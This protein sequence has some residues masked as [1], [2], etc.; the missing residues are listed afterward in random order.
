MSVEINS[1]NSAKP[2][3]LSSATF[4]RVDP[5]LYFERHLR[6]GLR[7][8]SQRGVDEFRSVLQQQGSLT[9]A[10]IGGDSHANL[11]NNCFGSC[12]VRS[13]HTSVACGIVVGTTETRGGAGIYPNVEI[14]RGGFS[15]APSAEE[16]VMSQRVSDLVK[17]MGFGAENFAVRIRQPDAEEEEDDEEDVREAWEKEKG[18]RVE[19][20]RWLVYTAHIQVLSRTGPPFDLVWAALMGA[21]RDVEVPEFE[22]DD[23]KNLFCVARR[24]GRKLAF[25]FS[26]VPYSSTFG[27]TTVDKGRDAELFVQGIAQED[28]DMDGSSGAAQLEVVVLAD[29]DGEIE[30]TCAPSQMDVV[31]DGEGVL[32]GFSFSAVGDHS[33][34]GQDLSHPGLV[35]E[36][37]HIERA[38]SL[39]QDRAR[40][41]G[42]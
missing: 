30:E 19:K 10:E 26:G 5:E 9:G 31:C 33:V 21:L 34:K 22:D 2:L 14:L 29:P 1:S 23:D 13:G 32:Y 25:P 17:S 37:A 6:Q 28:E 35:V 41:L 20:Q 16:M 39:A 36:R 11:F 4:A 38:L 27:V 7:P 24:T 42:R 12:V 15:S 8:G 3:W 40:D 18:F